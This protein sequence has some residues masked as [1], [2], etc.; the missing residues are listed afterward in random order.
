MAAGGGLYQ[1]AIFSTVL[2]IICLLLLGQVETHF[3][4]KPITVS[5][6]VISRSCE[7]SDSLLA[8]VNDLLQQMR[9]SMQTVS[10]AKT[11]D[12]HCRVQF[13]VEAYRSK[14]RVLAKRLHELLQVMTVAHTAIAEQD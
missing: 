9:L 7:S 6:D 14:Q 11:G 3:N 4:L 12:N 1:T 2:A 5:Y 8:E 10:L 13:E